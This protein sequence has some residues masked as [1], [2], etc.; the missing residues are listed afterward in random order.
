MST[1]NISPVPEGYTAVTPWIISRDMAG[2]LD[3][4]PRDRPG[5]GR[6]AHDGVRGDDLR[7]PAD[8]AT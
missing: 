1:A 5:D 4:G 8:R 7:L 2:L 3:F 6:V